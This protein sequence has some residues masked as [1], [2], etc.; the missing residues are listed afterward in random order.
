MIDYQDHTDGITASQLEGFFV[1]WP[2]PP[3][4][5]THLR[6]LRQSPHRI[7]ALDSDTRQVV[8]FINAISDGILS[9]YIPL[10]EVL[11]PYQGRGVGREL[12]K[13]MLHKLERLYMVDLVCLESLQPF[14]QKSGLQ[15]A[16]AMVIRNFD[17]QS[18]ITGDDTAG[19]DIE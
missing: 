2:N 7:V 6:I 11:P 1:G 9:A 3:S 19:K 14:Y 10:L 13:R 12:V 18:G 17:R 15:P 5:T 8:G 4:P 16:S